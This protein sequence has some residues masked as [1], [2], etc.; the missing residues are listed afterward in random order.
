[1]KIKRFVDLILLDRFD[2]MIRLQMTGTPAEC[3]DRLGITLSTLH[4]YIVYMR[5]VLK[6]SIRYSV[7]IQSYVYDS[8]PEFYLY[9]K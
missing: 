6:V 2:R 3:A 4:E 9:F 1:M 7:Y 8:N 5:K